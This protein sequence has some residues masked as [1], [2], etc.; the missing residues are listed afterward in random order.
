MC[1][2]VKEY[3][4]PTPIFHPLV[5]FLRGTYFTIIEKWV[6]LLIM[7]FHMNLPKNTEIFRPIYY[8]KTAYR[9]CSVR[10]LEASVR[11]SNNRDGTDTLLKKWFAEFIGVELVFWWKV[12][13]FCILPTHQGWQEIFSTCKIKLYFK[14]HQG[15]VLMGEM[16]KR[17]RSTYTTLIEDVFWYTI[18]GMSFLMR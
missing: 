2:R 4:S 12:S 15:G 10:P 6:H 13:D 11:P 18:T 16:G 14:K 9:K 7:E 3:K 1:G 5:H 8:L 17:S